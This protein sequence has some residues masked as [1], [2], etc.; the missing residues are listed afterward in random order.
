MRFPNRHNTCKFYDYGTDKLRE[1][2]DE[3]LTG[4]DDI[5]DLFDPSWL[6]LT[7]NDYQWGYCRR[8]GQPF[9][10]NVEKQQWEDVEH[11]D[12]RIA[13]IEYLKDVQDRAISLIAAGQRD[14]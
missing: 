11:E 14:S 1:A 5:H 9:H 4:A 2:H 8:C 3:V 6:G 10:W 13:W 7:P 12:V